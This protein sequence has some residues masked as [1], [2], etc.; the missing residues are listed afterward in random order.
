MSIFCNSYDGYHTTINVSIFEIKAST[1]NLNVE[2]TKFTKSS[3][4]A[5]QP[6]FNQTEL[7]FTVITQ[8]TSYWVLHINQ[9]LVLIEARVVVWPVRLLQIRIGTV[10]Q[11]LDKKLSL[12]YKIYLHV[13]VTIITLYIV[14]R[15]K[16]V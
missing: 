16:F 13:H 8:P 1:N 2:F 15:I 5:I 14:Y 7:P 11:H 6:D 12:I 4:A 9:N 3:E 10:F